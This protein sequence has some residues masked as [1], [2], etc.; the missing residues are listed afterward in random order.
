MADVNDGENIIDEHIFASI[1]VYDDLDPK[2]LEGLYL[3]NAEEFLDIIRHDD[4]FIGYYWLDS[5]EQVVTI[6]LFDTKEQA[7]ASK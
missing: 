1:R 3:R 2:G 7:T 6:S 4:G 5:G